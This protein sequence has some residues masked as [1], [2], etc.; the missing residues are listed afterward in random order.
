MAG[1]SK[2]KVRIL[3]DSKDGERAL[4]D[5]AR[6]ALEAQ[7]ETEKLNDHLNGVGKT[8]VK[9]LGALPALG[10]AAGAGVA[11]GL[12]AIPI[13]LGVVAAMALSTNEEVR[14]SFVDLWDDVKDTAQD[15]TKPLQSVLVGI[16]KDAQKTVASIKPDLEEMFTAAAPGL[17]EL[18]DGVMAFT[19]NIMPGMKKAVENSHAPMIG[20]GSLL[21][22]TGEGFSDFFTNISTES[23]SSARILIG[24]GRIVETTLGGTG[25]LLASLSGA[26]APHMGEIE[27]LFDNLFDSVNGLATG[28]LPVLGGTFGS[29]IGVL[30]GVLSVLEPVSGMLG[31]TVGTVLAAAAA[32]KI[33]TAATG[34]FG[35]LN[36]T[37]KLESAAL[38]AGVFTE[39]V[40]GSADAGER[41]ATSSSRAAQALAKMGN[42]LPIVGAVLIGL[43][44]A[45]E[46]TVSSNEALAA[47]FNKGGSAAEAANK[48]LALN[49][50]IQAT[51]ENQLGSLGSGIAT[52]AGDWLGLIPT[53]K[54]VAEEQKKINDAMSESEKR[55]AAAAKAQND[56]DLAV[57]NHGV[58]STEA[59]AAG[60]L[61][62]GVTRDNAIAQQQAA[63][64]TKSH[65]QRMIEQ[66]NQQ[67]LLV[68]SDLAYRDS[69]NA[70]ADAQR[71]AAEAVR[72][73]GASS[74][75]AA[76]AERQLEHA[77]LNQINSAAALAAATYKGTDEQEK[78]R[79]ATEA[80][81]REVLNLAAAN[82]GALSPSLHRTIANMNATQLAAEGVT[83]KVNAT[84]QAVL[85]MPG[86][87][88]ITLGLND[89]A[90][91]PL[92][93]A[94][95]TLSNIRDKTVTVRV[96]AIDGT[97]SSYNAAG[98]RVGMKFHAK[99][100]SLTPNAPAVVGEEGPEMIWP[101][102]RGY[103][104][105]ADETDELFRKMSA[106]RSMAIM[107]AG[108]P[109]ATAKVSKEVHMV[110]QH[111]EGD[112]IINVGDIIT[113]QDADDMYRQLMPKIK[114]GL[115]RENKRNTGNRTI[116]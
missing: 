56:Y 59:V 25:T 12:A 18:S 81:Q 49:T 21:S 63:D 3:G 108:Q 104:T 40:R 34:V 71:A 38:S 47:S 10:I 6:A 4:R 113:A 97:Y 65:T 16:A 86:G 80:A 66:M 46:S 70:T 13:A 9:A 73:K 72:L 102:K 95:N 32:W 74:E 79:L 45:F 100:G 98:A 57:K 52:V 77:Q 44:A 110:S 88:T 107:P 51:L 106:L 35:K 82:N 115:V 39:R 17:E 33:L 54:S 41:V 111:R 29:L 26:V 112:I 87:R 76:D 19:K 90:N 114:A 64:A 28:A 14:N 31:G 116:G 42:S 2:I 89:Y 7:R 48:Q 101:N 75:E 68:G 1:D 105:T 67:L 91:S 15:V 93:Q 78:S 85:S 36:L 109:M 24:F 84:G 11:G 55:S 50:A 99:G 62:A 69:V 94:V 103:V 8:S 20:L 5:Y 58:N 96:N 27:Q 61:L 60:Q 53:Q 37:S 43:H 30:N 22:D 83:V 23:G 92:Q